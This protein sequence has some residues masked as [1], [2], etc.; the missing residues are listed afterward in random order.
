[1]RLPDDNEITRPSVNILPMIDVIFAILAFFIL[2]TLYL[3]RAEGLPVNLP[4][5]VTATPQDQIDITLV[6]TSEG[7]LFLGDDAVLLENLAAEVRAIAPANPILVTIRADELTSHGQV[8]A[9]MDQLRTID[10]VRLGIAT[11]RP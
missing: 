11:T 2:S 4:Q 6:I 5:A 10:S 1:M 8:V 7:N 9:A 3:T